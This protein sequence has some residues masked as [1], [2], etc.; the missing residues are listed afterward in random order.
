MLHAIMPNQLSVEDDPKE[1]PQE[2]PNS[3]Q[4]MQSCVRQ[5]PKVMSNSAWPIPQEKKYFTAII[6]IVGCISRSSFGS[7]A[8]P[9]NFFHPKLFLN[10]N[11]QITPILRLPPLPL[12]HLLKGL[13]RWLR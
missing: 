10:L 2:T 3:S 11:L 4:P 1:K 13:L 9:R 12:A 7:F 8:L 6:R 5:I